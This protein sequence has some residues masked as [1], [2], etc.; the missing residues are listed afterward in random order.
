MTKG[1][2]LIT[3][4]GTGGH[5]FPA[6]V[7]KE[8]LEKN[9]YE[10]IVCADEK[11]AKY[12]KFDNQHILVPSANFAHKSIIK[13]MLSVF[14]LAFGFIKSLKIIMQVKPDIIF[15]FGGYASFPTLVAAAVL[16]K[17]IILHEANK[18]IGKVNRIFL[19]RASFLTTGFKNTLGIHQQYLT[20][21]IFTGNPVRNEIIALKK[22]NKSDKIN[23]LVIGGSQGARVFSKIIPEVIRKLSPE[24]RKNL[25]LHQQS[26]EEDIDKIKFQYKRNGI[27][28]EIKS[29][30]DDM[31]KRLSQAD[32]LISRAGASTIA[33]LIATETPSILIPF[34]S[35]ADN[36]Q[37]LN[38]KEIADAK[39]SWLLI[40]EPHINDKL[41]KLI[42]EI[43]INPEIIENYS[44]NLAKMKIDSNQLI[45]ES[46]SKLI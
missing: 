33:E 32:F 12:H 1:K 37:Y 3:T 36:H 29:F 7:C 45:V 35:S 4:G 42:T 15:G 6:L 9:G 5:I 24:I 17:K 40:E 2:I 22:Q 10:V 18:V 30:F 25:I 34:P 38:A 43:A 14:I 11:F 19:G 13:L 46:I 27:K 23:I 20:K 26:R 31:N 44:K 39:A 21:V 28:C 16:R 41:I 8:N